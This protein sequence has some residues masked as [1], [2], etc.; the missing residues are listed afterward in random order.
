MAHKQIT[1]IPA[2]DALNGTEQ[3][4]I[5]QGGNSRRMTTADL[6]R[7]ALEDYVLTMAWAA[8][9]TAEEEAGAAMFLH[10]FTESVTFADEFAGSQGYAQTPGAGQ[11]DFS[12]LRDQGAGAVAVGGVAIAA[13]GTVT[14]TT[15]GA[16]LDFVPGD[17]LIVV[18][19]SSDA[20]LQNYGFSL[21]G[22]RA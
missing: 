17:A 10:V 1:E 18:A 19:L 20:A 14:F 13:D 22:V 15:T 4:H 12:I 2:A 9:P 5:V 21:K 8:P 3:L 16:T 6:R 11:V 7:F